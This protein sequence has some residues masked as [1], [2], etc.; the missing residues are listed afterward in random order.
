MPSVFRTKDLSESG[1][2]SIR[3]FIGRLVN[4]EDDI[5]GDFGP[6]VSFTWEN[7][8]ILESDEPVVL[9]TG[10]FT[11]WVGKGKPRE[12]GRTN[13][14]SKYGRFLADWE[15]FAIDYLGSTKDKGVGD[16]FSMFVGKSITYAQKVY[17]FG[18][19]KSG[20]QMASKPVFVPVALPP[21]IPSSTK[22][23]VGTKSTPKGSA[24]STSSDKLFAAVVAAAADGATTESLRRVVGKAIPRG[25]M[26]QGEKFDN[27]LESL[28]ESG[29]LQV[30]ADGVYTVNADGR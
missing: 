19:D 18:K 3:K 20:E 28:V 30:D 7:V 4:F 8:E 26:P 6:Q 24:A 13:K 17:E 14:G 27:Y 9:A 23:T 10:Q 5:D 15:K 2:K 25:L 11:D 22:Q 16:N 1:L 21:S 29:Q 12:D